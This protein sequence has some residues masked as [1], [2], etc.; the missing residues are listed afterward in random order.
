VPDTCHAFFDANVC[1][2]LYKLS[3]ADLKELK[4]LVD[5]ID[6]GR[7]EIL[8]TSQVVDEI[9]RCRAKVIVDE[10]KS[11]REG[12]PRI[13]LPP[14]ARDGEPFEAWKRAQSAAAKAFQTVLDELEAAARERR[15][16]ADL[17]LSRF[18]RRGGPAIDCA[19]LLEAAR[20]RRALDEMKRLTSAGRGARCRVHRL[21]NA[22]RAAR[23][24]R[25]AVEYIGIDV[26]KN[27][28]QVCLL[29]EDGEILERRIATRRD[30]FADLLGSRPRARVV[31]EATTESEWVARCLESLGH[32]VIVA[33]PNYAPMYAT[34]S[35]RVKTDRRD[36]Q[37]RMDACR[38]GA[39][40]PTHRTSDTQREV[41]ALL[42][43]G[44]ASLGAA[45]GCA[46]STL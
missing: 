15:L 45:P 11:M 25:P 26:H 3:P 37:A 30:R 41:R 12:W 4:K 9:A 40:R 20:D 43:T 19:E 24:G 31:L 7:L 14:M 35:R 17:L 38:L 21:F 28:S 5:L 8:V 36:A 23:A 16:R 18:L 10:L 13:G 34:R 46:A 32:E 44:S 6:A 29:T 22:V 39:Y 1:L 2:S 27:E 33:D 42:T